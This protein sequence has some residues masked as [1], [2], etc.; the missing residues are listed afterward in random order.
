MYEKLVPCTVFFVFNFLVIFVTEER[1]L[2]YK[3]IFKLCVFK[4][5]V[6]I[7]VFNFASFTFFMIVS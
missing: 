5:A 1:F 3:I 4:K 7:F 6:A 2:F